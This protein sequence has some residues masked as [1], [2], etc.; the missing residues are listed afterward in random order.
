MPCWELKLRFLSEVSALTYQ[1]SYISIP[2]TFEIKLHYKA[3]TVREHFRP[4]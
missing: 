3:L 1:L 2:F 4:C